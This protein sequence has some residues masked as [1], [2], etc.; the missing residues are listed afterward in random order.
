MNDG[1]VESSAARLDPVNAELVPVALVDG[2]DVVAEVV[3]QAGH[4]LEV[5]ASAALLLP[6]LHVVLEWTERDECVVAGASTEHLCS[7]MSN[8]RVTHGL[9]SGAVVVVELASEQ[10]Q[11]IL[12]E[13][14]AVI[15][16][17]RRT[18]FNQE[19]LLVGEVLG[20]PAGNDTASS[21]TTDYD[22]VIVALRVLRE[23]C[24]SHLV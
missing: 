11:P 24:G 4:G 6:H 5:P 12:E 19:D 15:H 10:V 2:V 20:E 3:Q 9:L 23:V 7:R 8:V 17:I 13:K 18:S 22:K 21:A 16:E 1:D 14:D